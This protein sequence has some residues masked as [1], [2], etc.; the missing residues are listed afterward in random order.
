[1]KSALVFLTLSSGLWAHSTAQI[2]G[3]I[4]DAS[5]AAVPGAVIQATQTE[6]SAVRKVISDATGSHALANLPIGPY[7]LEISKPRFAT[8]VQTGIVLQL[9]SH[10]TL[11]GMRWV[12]PPR[13]ST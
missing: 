9:E 11:N 13:S 3:T 7:R 1:M 4:Q 8:Y 12:M 2:Q 5:G 6:T 10:P